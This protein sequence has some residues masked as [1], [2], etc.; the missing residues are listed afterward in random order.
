M[1]FRRGG[2]PS[3]GPIRGKTQETKVYSTRSSTKQF[4]EDEPYAEPKFGK[5]TNKRMHATP[6]STSSSTLEGRTK[7][8]KREQSLTRGLPQKSFVNELLKSNEKLITIKI[9]KRTHARNVGYDELNISDTKDSTA[10]RDGTFRSQNFEQ[11]SSTVLNHHTENSTGTDDSQRQYKSLPTDAET[12]QRLLHEA[13]QELEHA[14]TS[15]RRLQE[16]QK[17]CQMENTK[18]CSENKEMKTRINNLEDGHLRAREDRG[19]SHTITAEIWK[20]DSFSDSIDQMSEAD[21]RQ[22]LE[23]L[24]N[25][26][27]EFSDCVLRSVASSPVGRSSI[28]IP[29]KSS[30]A[31]ATLYLYHALNDQS[32]SENNRA[33]LLESLFHHEIIMSLHSIFFA[34]LITPSSL[35]CETCMDI[36]FDTVFRLVCDQQDWSIS[37]RWRSISAAAIFREC[38]GDPKWMAQV[39]DLLGRLSAILSLAYKQPIERFEGLMINH[40]AELVELYEQ[41]Y[42]LS[43]S[44]KRDVLSIRMSVTLAPSN[45]NQPHKFKKFNPTTTQSAWPNMGARKG[46]IILGMYK[47]GLVK[48]KPSGEEI[49]LVPCQVVTDALLKHIRC[50]R[51]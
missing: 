38:N 32:L 5:G 3:S 40:Q 23:K 21:V 39:L 44:C 11:E 12:L 47:W 2:R 36:A 28:N 4:H 15:V 49:C 16:V 17:N 50:S 35:N 45:V 51:E 26:V 19:S 14:K 10:F 30:T 37:Q 31:P 8:P 24:N 27:E 34:A 29:D 9:P 48:Q 41:A 7:R 46:D 6:N 43:V 33:F 1:P 25:D 13:V 42:A 20:P 22:M 18:L